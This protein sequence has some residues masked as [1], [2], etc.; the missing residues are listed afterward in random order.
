MTAYGRCA[1]TTLSL[2]GTIQYRDIVST[3]TI[4]L[5][6]DTVLTTYHL[7]SICLSYLKSSANI[8]KAKND[9]QFLEE[10]ML[11]STKG[12]KNMVSLEKKQD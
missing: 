1:H 2:A 9:G 3:C 4:L 8:H 7:V 10:E 12:K 11:S 5:C 6:I